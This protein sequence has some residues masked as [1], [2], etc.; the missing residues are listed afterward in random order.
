MD[1][2]DNWKE[3]ESAVWDLVSRPGIPSTAVTFSP[4]LSGDSVVPF[5]ADPIR[6]FKVASQDDERCK[7]EGAEGR[8][9]SIPLDGMEEEDCSVWSTSEGTD[10]VSYGGRQ[11]T[12]YSKAGRGKGSQ[13]HLGWKWIMR[14]PTFPF[15]TFSLCF[16]ALAIQAYILL[17]T[18]IGVWNGTHGHNVVFEISRMTCM[19]IVLTYSWTNKRMIITMTVLLGG[20]ISNEKK[21]YMALS[22]WERRV[23]DDLNQS[24]KK[25]CIDNVAMVQPAWLYV[26]YHDIYE[27]CSPLFLTLFAIKPSYGCKCIYCIIFLFIFIILYHSVWCTESCTFM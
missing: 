14:T 22:H 9:L 10:M 20:Y 1:V 6:E 25:S 26:P 23:N 21:D 11:W 19:L 17:R 7:V 24:K 12:A 27:C 8:L 4:G 3:S 5:I 15:L 18:L 13:S 2:F 16:I